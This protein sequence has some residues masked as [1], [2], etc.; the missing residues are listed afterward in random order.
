MPKIIKNGITYTPDAST[1]TNGSSTMTQTSGVLEVGSVYQRGDATTGDA[2]TGVFKIFSGTS[3]PD[4]A[5]GQNGD[6]YLKR[7]TS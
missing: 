5:L 3:D 7:I 4:A 6:I 2:I 1:L